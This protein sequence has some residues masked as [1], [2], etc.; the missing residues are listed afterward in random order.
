MAEFIW[1][2]IATPKYAVFFSKIIKLLERKGINI[3]VTSRYSED[4]TEVVALLDL[5]GIEHKIIGSYGGNTPYGKFKSRLERQY[6]FLELFD[7]IGMPLC[8]FCGCVVDS[9]QFS[10]G[11]GIPVINFSDTPSYDVV[12]Y[13][14]VPKNFTA[15]SK[16]TLPISN[17]IF[18]PFVLPKEIYRGIVVDENVLHS[19]DFIDVHLWMNEIYGGKRG[20]DFRTK[21]GIPK[22]KPTILLREEEYKANY[23]KEKIDI[24]YK[25][26]PFLK[27]FDVNVV[28]MPRYDKE[29]LKSNF[30]DIAYVLEEKVLPHEFYPYVDMIIGGGGTMNLEACYLG[31]PT[32]STRSI[33][34]Y[35]DQYLI[36]NNIMYW[37]HDIK[38]ILNIVDKNIGKKFDNRDYFIKDPNAVEKLIDEIFKIIEGIR[39]RR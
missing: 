16:L 2:D 39:C 26:I 38:E 23:V 7:N 35:H 33:W 3:V 20:D 1:F 15:V 17:Y 29:S 18:Y 36:K 9:I 22:H 30:G 37:S 6:G 11:V 12:G 14:G 31:I 8:C 4:Y 32:I 10:F 5:F 27:E 24:I 25:V 34:L 13:F 21:F 28:I 19:Y